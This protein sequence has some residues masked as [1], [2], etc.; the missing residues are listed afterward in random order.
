MKKFLILFLFSVCAFADLIQVSA[1]GQSAISKAMLTAKSGDTIILADGKYYEDVIVSS[2]VTLYSPNV[3][4][5]QIIGNG[6]EAVVELKMNSSISGVVVSNGRNGIVTKNSG[7]L[8]ENCY[9]HSNQGSGI[10][11]INRFPTIQNSIIANNLNSGIQGTSIISME[12]ELRRL[13]IADNRRNGIEIDGEQKVFLR[14]CLFFKNANKAIKVDKNELTL[15]NLL[16]FPE[17]KDLVNKQEDLIARPLFTGKFYQLKDDS[18]GKNKAS[19]GKDI[20]FVR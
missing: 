10:L 6:R 19:D 1:V 16:I 13:T 17:Q 5:A 8:I 12:G 3:F 15:V 18:P 14:D 20:G 4:G 9:V 11:A 2:G 7:A